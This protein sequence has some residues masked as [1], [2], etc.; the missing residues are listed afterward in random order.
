[1]VEGVFM[2]MG[3]MG[4]VLLWRIAKYLER[5][6]LEVQGKREMVWTCKECRSGPVS[7]W[8]GMRH[9]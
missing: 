9:G 3:M 7:R 8:A 1:M 6:V 5:L 4:L 2:G